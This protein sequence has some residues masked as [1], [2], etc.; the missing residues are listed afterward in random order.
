V[1]SWLVDRNRFEEYGLLRVLLDCAIVREYLRELQVPNEVGRLPG[2]V[3]QQGSGS[4][5]RDG[6]LAGVLSQGV[7]MSGSGVLGG[8]DAFHSDDSIEYR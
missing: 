8:G 4:L 3:T 2:Q 1:T 7:H 6:I 5:C